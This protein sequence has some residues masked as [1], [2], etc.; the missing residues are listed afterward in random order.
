MAPKKKKT[1]GDPEPG[2]PLNSEELFLALQLQIPS[3]EKLLV[4]RTSEVSEALVKEADA[5]AF[6]MTLEEDLKKQFEVTE[7][8]AA[9]LARQ[10]K[11][12]QD[13]L[14]TRINSLDTT[15]S[16]Y[17]E[18]AQLARH[19]IGTLRAEKGDMILVREHQLVDL[20]KRLNSMCSEFAQMLQVS[21]VQIKERLSKMGGVQS[22]PYLKRLDDYAIEK[23]MTM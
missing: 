12:T 7:A 19:E 6:L 18:E 1:K 10:Y 13:D 16:E 4:E 23:H 15:W 17:E 5:K 11:A 22:A 21:N 20:R 2:V 14:I 9:D 8:I 3:L